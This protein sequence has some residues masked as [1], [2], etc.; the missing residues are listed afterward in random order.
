MRPSLRLGTVVT[1]LLH[2]LAC[3]GDV[4][5]SI[6]SDAVGPNLDVT[7]PVR[8]ADLGDVETITVQGSSSAP[9]LGDVEVFVSRWGGMSLSGSSDTWPWDYPSVSGGWG[10]GPFAVTVPAR[11]GM[12][13][14]QTWADDPL[15]VRTHDTRSVIVGSR[16]GQGQA[17]PDAF[18]VRI[19]ASDMGLG[20][21]EAILEAQFAAFDPA[22]Y[23]PDPLYSACDPVLCS[24][25]LD[26]HAQSL[27]FDPAQIHLDPRADGRIAATVFLD[28]VALSWWADANSSL[29]VLFSEDG[30]V[31]A[32]RLEL[33]VVF[34]PTIE[35]TGQVS[36]E[37]L[38]LGLEAI[39]FD[40]DVSNAL[41]DVIEY[42]GVDFDGIVLAGLQ[43]SVAELGSEVA[44]GL[45]EQL[46]TL[47]AQATFEL[48]VMESSSVLVASSLGTTIAPSH[49][50]IDDDAVVVHFDASV[51]T[52]TGQVGGGLYRAT[53]MPQGP[54]GWARTEGM[55]LALD[56]NFVNQVLHLSR[57][58]GVLDYSVPIEDLG[59]D[60]TIATPLLPDL[61]GGTVTLTSGMDPVVLPCGTE[62]DG[63]CP[64]RQQPFD[65]NVFDAVL[66]LGSLHVVVA[67]AQGDAVLDAHVS[68]IADMGFD[69]SDAMVTPLIGATQIWL[70]VVQP[71]S[72]DETVEALL[73]EL[74]LSEVSQLTVA[75]EAIPL[76]TF[77]GFRPVLVQAGIHDGSD[78]FGASG[79]VVEV[80][81]AP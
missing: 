55:G 25:S 66:Q 57:A 75:L 64:P 38:E 32:D 58:E 40:L 70:D 45:A 15:G 44:A 43:E 49:L 46:A 23:V 17:V 47:P 54:D 76:P 71:E 21:V 77:A 41:F 35:P 52:P 29:G 59:I 10:S 50:E 56:L 63:A 73:R 78:Y 2:Q 12:N 27:F 33:S 65:Q 60:P 18:L 74:V 9:V 1:I 34:R 20:T 22:P 5:P 37:E 53:S 13:L 62:I 68:A 28:D 42:L 3:T 24:V 51:Q 67:D 72:I 80:V 81:D 31:T 39:G 36:V 30:T 16:L 26:V 6:V 8:G 19:D 61:T 14:L 79:T 11:F 4:G 7:S 48:P 69:L